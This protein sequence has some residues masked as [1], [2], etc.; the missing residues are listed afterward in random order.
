LDINRGE[1]YPELL[2]WVTL[3]DFSSLVFIGD[4]DD[5]GDNYYLWAAQLDAD[6][7]VV[8]YTLIDYLQDAFYQEA[9][10]FWFPNED[11]PEN[12]YGLLF[13]SLII[14]KNWN[15][16]NQ[17]RYHVDRFD[18]TGQITR[19]AES[20]LD[21]DLPL[22]QTANGIWL[23]ANQREG[24]IG[25]VMAVGINEWSDSFIGHWGS[26]AYFLEYNLNGGI[27][28]AGLKRI[29]QKNNGKSWILHPYEPVWN[30]ASWMIPAVETKLKNEKGQ[31]VTYGRRWN[32]KLMTV[33][34]TPTASNSEIKI[35]KRTLERD[36]THYDIPYKNPMFLRPNPVDLGEESLSEKT[37]V[38]GHFLLYTKAMFKA[39]LGDHALTAINHQHYLRIVNENGKNIE[40]R[41]ELFTP[42][43]TRKFAP[44][45]DWYVPENTDFFSNAL[46]IENGH[47]FIAQSR[48]AYFL[49]QANASRTK[50]ELQLDLYLFNPYENH[51]DRIETKS[52]KGN[53]SSATPLLKFIAG[54]P[55]MINTFIKLKRKKSSLDLYF[56][57]F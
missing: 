17:I 56:S 28:P 48:S 50:S 47:Y 37:V 46:F 15:D 43:W 42:E 2:D 19:N 7:N 39:N 22:N 44:H 12:S 10:A 25:V 31:G 36:N 40:P 11:N 9:R 21:I 27:S 8:E 57:R 23:S 18:A 13:T 54:A 3:N 51:F 16:Q 4:W 6:G 20:L 38:H 41:Q 32:H 45:P 35:K 33:V 14:P 29:P 30:G 34:A 1:Y 52:L 53:F 5:D 24:V 55:C 26:Q 49:H